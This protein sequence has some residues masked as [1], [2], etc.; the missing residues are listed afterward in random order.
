MVRADRHRNGDL[1]CAAPGTAMED[2]DQWDRLEV[3]NSPTPRKIIP[4]SVGHRPVPAMDPR[5]V[6]T[7]RKG[8]G[9]R[10]EV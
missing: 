1:L 7:R 3:P 2:R 9:R 6:A 4:T 8:S 5:W 10:R